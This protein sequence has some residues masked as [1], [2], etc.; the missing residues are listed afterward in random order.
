MTGRAA[1][2]TSDRA[3]H[4]PLW[5]EQVVEW[6]RPYTT[7]E[8]IKSLGIAP[9]AGWIKLYGQNIWRGGGDMRVKVQ[10]VICADA[11]GTDTIHDVAVLEKDCHRIEQLGLTL[12]E[13]KQLLTRLQ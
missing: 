13:A 4:L 2:V 12:A 7:E 3:R 9:P 1:H 11:E 5:V 10:L 6:D 8:C